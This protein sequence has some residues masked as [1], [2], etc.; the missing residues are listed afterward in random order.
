MWQYPCPQELLGPALPLSLPYAFCH[1]EHTIKRHDSLFFGISNY[2]HAYEFNTPTTTK[3][4]RN[5]VFQIGT[6]WAV[7]GQLRKWRAGVDC[8]Q[9]GGGLVRMDCLFIHSGHTEKLLNGKECPPSWRPELNANRTLLFEGTWEQWGLSL[10]TPPHTSTAQC[11]E[12]GTAS[13]CLGE[14][15]KVSQ[16]R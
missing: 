2:G 8:G 6:G 11:E 4:W 13:F 5:A 16:R 15:G 1:P 7:T 10:P 14:S 12:I 9:S 3:V